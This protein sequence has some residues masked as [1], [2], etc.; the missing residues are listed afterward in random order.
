MGRGNGAVLP[1]V[2][3]CVVFAA[4]PARADTVYLKTG[5]VRAMTVER[6]SDGAFWVRD[7]KR[8]VIY[9]P[10]EIIKIVFAESIEHV[11]QIRPAA[12]PAASRTPAARHAASSAALLTVPSAAASPPASSVPSDSAEAQ[13]VILNY[14]AN[15]QKGIFQIVGEVAS[16]MQTE[17]RYVKIT[18]TLLAADGDAL[19]QNF[20]Y[21]LPS[22]PHLKPGE[23]KSFRVSFIRP[24]D[25][26]AKY[27]I[28][29]E[30]S[31]F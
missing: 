17:A 31:P 12:G 11:A 20:S 22:P 13:L 26:I 19:D 6:Y 7:G 14:R 9:R 21:V 24:P 29:V 25:G 23:T 28:R 16:R 10:E 3:L 27:K 2:L 4:C 1:G 8:T 18:V 5:E 30:S 15:A